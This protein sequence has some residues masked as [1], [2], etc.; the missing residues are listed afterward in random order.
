MKIYKA[1][2]KRGAR[3]PRIAI[4]QNG[5]RRQE[6]YNAFGPKVVAAEELI[7]NK[8]FLE[9]CIIIEMAE[10]IPEKD[11]YDKEDEA[12]FARLRAEL[13]KWRMAVL[14]GREK[15]PEL[16]LEWLKG[17]DRE[18]YLPLLTVLKGTLL[19]S[20]LE[21][22]IRKLIERKR[23]EKRGSL[24]AQIIAVVLE[25]AKENGAEIPFLKIWDRLKERLNAVVPSSSSLAIETAMDTEVYGRITK[26]KIGAILR[27]KL[28]LEKLKTHRDGKPIVL[29]RITDSE[30]FRRT[31][32]KYGLEDPLPI[33]SLNVVGSE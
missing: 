27:D 4:D 19:Y 28:G 22:K 11:H 21:E 14:A 5:R 15:L 16:E 2:Y 30:K 3:V 20:I 29:Y 9:R 17:R 33:S 26:T 24:E 25:L 6:F 32:I 1:G 12:R 7:E 10:G 31:A 13:L 8:G 18:L 23:E